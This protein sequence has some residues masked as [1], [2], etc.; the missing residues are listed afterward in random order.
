MSYFLLTF[1]FQFE[2]PLRA[3]FKV[4]SIKCERDRIGSAFIVGSFTS[5]Y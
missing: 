1:R 3:L 5:D 4:L 2:V